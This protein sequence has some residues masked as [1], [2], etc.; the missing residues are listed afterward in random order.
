MEAQYILAA[1]VSVCLVGVSVSVDLPIIVT[2]SG[3]V[4]VN[5]TEQENMQILEKHF[6]TEVKGMHSKT[7]LRKKFNKENTST[8][9]VRSGDQPW[10]RCGMWW[11]I[12]P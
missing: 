12:S 10:L 8:R 2:N 4:I 7:F 1:C 9:Q 3:R 6:F 11:S 5:G